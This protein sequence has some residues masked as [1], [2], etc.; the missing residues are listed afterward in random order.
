L[1]PVSFGASNN[2]I[3]EI[4]L[5]LL[6]TLHNTKNIAY[7]ITK[8]LIFYADKLVVMGNSKNLRVFNFAILLKS[9]KSLKFDAREIYM[10]YSTWF[11]VNAAASSPYSVLAVTSCTTDWVPSGDS[12]NLVWLGCRY[13]RLC[14]TCGAGVQCAAVDAIK[15]KCNKTAVNATPAQHVFQLMLLFRWVQAGYILCERQP[16]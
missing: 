2:V 5:L 4:H 11:T 3:I 14:A 16:V 8:V 1:F 10:F 15:V 6:F 7:H 9:R 12:C 13:Y